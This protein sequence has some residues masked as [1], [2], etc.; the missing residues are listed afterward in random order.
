MAKTYKSRIRLWHV[1][2]GYCP[3]CN[4]PVRGEKCEMCNSRPR[5]LRF[6][7]MGDIRP[8]SAHERELFISLIP[9]DARGYF[10]RR[11]ILLARQPGLDYRKDVYVDGYKVGIMEYAHRDGWHW[12]FIPTGKGAALLL[13]FAEPEFTLRTAGHLKGKKIQKEISGEWAL[14][15]AGNCAGVAVRTPSGVK[16]KDIFCHAVKPA[17]KSQLED[18]VRANVSYLE[19]I[20]KKAVS[21]IKH[22]GAKYVA[23]S[24]GKDSEVALYLAH[25]AGVKKAIYANTG[26]EFPESSRFVKKFADFLGVELIEV[27]PDRGFWDVVEEKGIP[28]KENRWCT[29]HLKLAQLSKFHGVLVDGTRRYESFGRMRRTRTAKLGN[30]KLIYPILDWLA[31]D[32]WLYIHYRGLPYNPL[33]DMGYER[34]GCYMCPSMLNAEFHNMRST[35]PELFKRW[36]EY[37]RKQGFTHDEIMDGVWRWS[38]MPAKLKEI[39]KS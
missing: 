32:V 17:K 30:L 18:A 2:I 24:G 1:E 7:D 26:L 14:F 39:R 8:A 23:F 34:I 21:M 36:Y 27:R 35:H 4:V 19:K 9:R 3:R 6:H 25:L 28:T 10:K 33:Y 29:K 20:E 5:S 12:R 13:N 22:S 38:E 15:R 31:L 37:L 11:I 16:V